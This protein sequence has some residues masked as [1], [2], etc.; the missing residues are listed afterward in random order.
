MQGI[1]AKYLCH[2]A[3][4]IWQETLACHSQYHAAI[5]GANSLYHCPLHI[6]LPIAGCA[7]PSS[8]TTYAM[9]SYLFHVSG[10]RCAHCVQAIED[11][12]T[13]LDAAA[14]VHVDLAQ[15]TVRVNSSAHTVAISQAIAEEGFTVTGT[16]DAIS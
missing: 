4:D 1:M 9:T 13:A 3:V 12:I 8:V 7:A 5:A 16:S 11:A 15:G 2:D 14:Q 6:Q 10:M